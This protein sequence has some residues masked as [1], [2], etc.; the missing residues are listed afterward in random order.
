MAYSSKEGACIGEELNLYKVAHRCKAPDNNPPERKRVPFCWKAASI[1]PDKTVATKLWWEENEQITSTARFRICVAVDVREEKVIELFTLKTK[2]IIGT[3][4]I[5]F[6]SVFQ[7]YESIISRKDSITLLREGLGMRMV[8]GKEPLWFFIEGSGTVPLEQSFKPHLLE[9]RKE[10]YS[11]TFEERFSTL[12]SLQQFGWMA[13]C[14][15]DGLMDLGYE[16]ATMAHLSLFMDKEKTRLVYEDPRSVPADGQ[17]YGIESLLPI[18]IIAKVYSHT[19]IL[20]DAVQY[21]E[22]NMDE[23]GVIRDTIEVS[24]E[25]NYTIA[26]PLACL[27]RA[28]DRDD[29]ALQSL[30]QL[31]VRKEVLW[32]NKTLY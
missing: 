19:S 6:A 10:F 13:G 8:I 24:A 26:Y 28:L 7:V 9:N 16:E 23:K 12:A 21:M 4:D 15:L 20:K 22:R 5:R 11:R 29:L 14:V 27:A 31:S 32:R 1:V 2:K 18:A 3:L 30:Y 17:F 25:G